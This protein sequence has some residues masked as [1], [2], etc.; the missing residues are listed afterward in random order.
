[1][2]EYGRLSRSG[3]TSKGVVMVMGE[4]IKPVAAERADESKKG[5]SAGDA[6][7]LPSQQVSSTAIEPRDLEP[8]ET[9]KDFAERAAGPR[10]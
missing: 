10:R 1:M 9:S 7:R 6:G 2:P 3:F 8:D 4:R 5:S